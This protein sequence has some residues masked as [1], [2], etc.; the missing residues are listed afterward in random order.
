MTRLQLCNMCFCFPSRQLA[1]IG[2]KLDESVADLFPL[3]ICPLWSICCSWRSSSEQ[4]EPLGIF[5]PLP[6]FQCFVKTITGYAQIPANPVM[7]ADI[8]CVSSQKCILI[9]ALLAKDLLY[10]ELDFGWEIDAWMIATHMLKH[11]C[12]DNVITKCIIKIGLDPSEKGQILESHFGIVAIYLAKNGTSHDTVGLLL[13]TSGMHITKCSCTRY[14]RRSTTSFASLHE[15][16]ERLL[17]IHP[18]LRLNDSTPTLHIQLLQDCTESTGIVCRS[19]FL[20]FSICI[21]FRL[22]LPR[23]TTDFCL[24]KRN[25]VVRLHSRRDM[26]HE[27]SQQLAKLLHRW[28][29]T[30]GGVL[31]QQAP[32]KLPPA[33][34]TL[35]WFHQACLGEFQGHAACMQHESRA[36]LQEDQHQV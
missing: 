32:Q 15:S 23:D 34:E 9:K 36:L 16:L 20:P 33:F 35:S 3:C 21:N 31:R 26:V 14:R 30:D 27:L 11:S 13:L 4:L 8:D 12:Q 2:P 6:C 1:P 5:K 7:C 24:T 25:T 17:L 22:R 10:C 19:S 29:H 28:C 18:H